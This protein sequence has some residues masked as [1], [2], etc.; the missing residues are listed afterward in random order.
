MAGRYTE[1]VVRILNFARQEAIEAGS[2]LIEVEHLLLGLLRDMSD[3]MVIL[4]RR[5]RLDPR[6]MYAEVQRRI[7]QSGP[8]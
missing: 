4:L 8:F 7:S 5:F 6:E 2:N 1:R 3:P